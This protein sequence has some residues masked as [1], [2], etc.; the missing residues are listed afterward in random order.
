MKRDGKVMWVLGCFGT[1]NKTGKRV[2]FRHSWHP[3]KWGEGNCNWCGR[4]L[5]DLLEVA[6]YQ[7]D[8]RYRPHRGSL[9]DAML[10]AVE[11]N[12]RDEFIAHL[13]KA[14]ASEVNESGTNV[15]VKKY[16]DGIDERIGWDTHIVLVAGNP[17][18]FTDGPVFNCGEA[19]EL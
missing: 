18:G 9:A 5:K 2:G 7:K 19:S 11:L 12:G 3:G 8:I 4:R 10:E 1:S 16:G 13:R 6:D 14:Y 15:V 17:Y